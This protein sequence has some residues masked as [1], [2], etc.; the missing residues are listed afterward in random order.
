MKTSKN[1]Q[2][3]YLDSIESFM[4]RIGPTIGPAG[5]VPLSEM[6][7]IMNQ[8]KLED[9]MQV[10]LS[11]PPDD[12]RYS[13]AFDKLISLASQEYAP[14]EHFLGILYLRDTN[15]ENQ[16]KG[17]HWLTRAAEQ[18]LLHS[19]CDLAHAYLSGLGDM[20]ESQ[21]RG[22]EWLELSAANG[23]S[24]SQYDLAELYLKDKGDRWAKGRA[25][26]LVA[27]AA[28]N[29]L[30]EAEYCFAMM[31]EKGFGVTKNWEL[32]FR[33]MKKAADTGL[34]VAQLDLVRYYK[35]GIGTEI[36]LGMATKYLSIIESSEGLE[37]G[38]SPDC[39]TVLN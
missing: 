8:N 7:E 30:L 17:I 9:I 22:R 6:I 11:T 14:A 36:D 25:A 23:F 38:M 31:L 19:Q 24:E 20:P 34:Y 13:T 18:G 12:A 26:K 2:G 10:L 32:A 1:A 15:V 29:G 35:L 28:L 21:K 33:L 27:S 16:K 37:E 39:S 4:F 3:S 5:P